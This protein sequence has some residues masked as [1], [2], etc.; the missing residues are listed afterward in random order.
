MLALGLTLALMAWLLIWSGIT[1]A[2]PLDE[3]RSAFGPS[4]PARPAK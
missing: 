1:G 3:I 4:G 2:N